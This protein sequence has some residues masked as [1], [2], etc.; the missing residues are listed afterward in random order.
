[1]RRQDRTLDKQRA[2]EILKNGEYGV[3]SMRT[4]DGMGAYG[5]P[6]NYVWDG[7]QTILVHC[8]P[9]GR[10]LT[11]IDTCKNVSFCV[12]GRTN[13]IADKFT[14]GY[15]SIILRCVASHHLPTEERKEALKKFIGKYSPGHQEIGMQY[16]EKSFSR[17]EILRLD[18]LEISGK[19]KNLF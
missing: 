14:T 16:A 9:E 12:V 5:V 1:M 8:A 7:E 17:T 4:E 6:L 10:K 18:I 3:L 13:V 2:F 19:A 11:C 15:E